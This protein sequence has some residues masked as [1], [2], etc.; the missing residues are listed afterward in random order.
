MKKAVMVVIAGLA[1][2]FT[3]ST[4]NQKQ[5]LSAGTADSVSPLKPSVVK[6]EAD[7]GRMP[8]YFIANKGQLDERVDYYV[9]GRDKSLYFS[10]G[11]VTFVLASAESSKQ[12]NPRKG[13]SG[14][15]QKE[16]QRHS[17]FSGDVAGDSTKES[18]GKENKSSER[19]VVKLEFVGADCA[20]RPQGQDETGAVF[21]YFKGKPEE[22]RTG[23]PTYSRLTYR[24]LWPGIDLVYSGTTNKLKYEFIVQPGADPSRIKAGL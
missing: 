4:A 8:L 2:L 11:S 17:L 22:W 10:P 13:L 20:V 19:W 18:T 3:V 24:N 12:E 7:F 6:L 14:M 23:L 5:G 9:Q 15:K 21:S 1:C 16:A